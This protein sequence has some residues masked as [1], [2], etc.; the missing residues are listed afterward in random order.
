[1]GYGLEHTVQPT[2]HV[3]VSQGWR[4][5]EMSMRRALLVES[6]AAAALTTH[7]PWSRERSRTGSGLSSGWLL[8][9][10]SHDRQTERLPRVRQVRR[11]RLVT[12][13]IGAIVTLVALAAGSSSDTSTGSR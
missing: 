6:L 10:C 4:V 11:S 8:P 7:S 1:M 2:R 13:S 12:W 3:K 5:G 9:V